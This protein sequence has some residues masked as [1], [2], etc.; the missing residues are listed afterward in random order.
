M[1]TRADAVKDGRRRAGASYSA[2]ARPRLDGGEHGVMLV[3]SGR[4]RVLKCSRFFIGCF[5]GLRQLPF[6]PK[7]ESIYG[8]AI[9]MISA[10][11]SFSR[12]SSGTLAASAV[13]FP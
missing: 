7:L 9:A 12:G 2:V 13:G 8:T 11:V 5:Y 6:T 10:R 1:T 4:L 3:G